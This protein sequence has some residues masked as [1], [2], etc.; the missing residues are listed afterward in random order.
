MPYAH[1]VES[2]ADYYRLLVHG[3]ALLTACGAVGGRKALD[4][5]CGQGYFS[6]LLA[7]AGAVVTGL[8]LSDGLI[9]RAVEIETREPLGIS[10]RQGDA[11]PDRHALR[12]GELRSGDGMHVAT[13]RV[14]PRAVLAGACRLLGRSGRAVF[15]VP[16]PCTDPPVR[17][18]RR[19]EQGRKL[20]LCLDRYFESGPA[21]CDWNMPR[22]R[23]AWRTPFR[24]FTL[25]EWSGLI[26]N[27][28]FVIRALAEPRPDAAL[29]AAHPVLDD[30]FRMPFFLIF[31]LVKS[32]SPF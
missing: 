4:V 16:H 31:D 32:S 28:G 3:P 5:G 2:G 10:Y 9:A 17:E 29:V 24:R 15:S 22:L 26:G 14:R 30:C 11:D 21:V 7:G 13:G 27:A 12:R 25:T 20:A 6:R 18:W 19:D 23:Y 8:D 1:F